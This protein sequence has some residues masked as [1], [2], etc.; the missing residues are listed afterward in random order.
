M[1]KDRHPYM[2]GRF[3]ILGQKVPTDWGEFPS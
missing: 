2:R 3:L 1:M